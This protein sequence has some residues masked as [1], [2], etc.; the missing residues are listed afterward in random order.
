M[1]SKKPVTGFAN[2]LTRKEPEATPRRKKD[3]KEDRPRLQGEGS[4]ADLALLEAMRTVTKRTSGELLVEGLDLVHAKL[5]KAQR[6]LVAA[7][8]K[9]GE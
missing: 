9:R 6:D 4:A 2:Q 3:K 7:L 1:A 8:V 5:T